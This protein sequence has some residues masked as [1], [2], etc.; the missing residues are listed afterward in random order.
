MTGS[1]AFERMLGKICTREIG[2][3]STFRKAHPR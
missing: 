2:A 3:Y 1:A